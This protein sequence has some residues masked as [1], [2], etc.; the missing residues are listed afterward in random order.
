MFT[1]EQLK[2]INRKIP[3]K[4]LIYMVANNPVLID[5]EAFDPE[6]VYRCECGT[7]VPYAE[8][9]ERMKTYNQCEDCDSTAFD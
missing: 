8:A 4:S 5:G 7:A 9:T 6:D 3:R 2:R 1:D